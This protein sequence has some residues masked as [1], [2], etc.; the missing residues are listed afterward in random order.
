MHSRTVRLV[1]PADG[2]SA[3]ATLGVSPARFAGVL[4]TLN[5]TNLAPDV[6]LSNMGQTLATGTN[7][8][9]EALIALLPPAELLV[10]GTIALVGS[11]ATPEGSITAQIFLNYN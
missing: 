4:F 11:G 3:T 8:A 6:V 10:S 2:G 1:V 9:N 7:I 5:P